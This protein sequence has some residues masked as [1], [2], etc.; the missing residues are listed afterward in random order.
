[1]EP[2][3]QDNPPKRVE[4]ESPIPLSP[5]PGSRDP[6]ISP[7]HPRYYIEDEMAVFLVH[8]ICFHY[9]PHHLIYALRDTG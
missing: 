1:M 9:C 5:I 8:T 6:K 2:S 7:H 4:P 3:E